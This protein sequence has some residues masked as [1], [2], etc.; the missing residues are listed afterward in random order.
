ML[1]QEVIC[2][3]SPEAQ[4]LK[5]FASAL[6]GAVSMDDGVP[7]IPPAF[8]SISEKLAPFISSR[9][10]GDEIFCLVPSLRLGGDVS[11]DD[12]HS[13]SFAKKA[14][15][16]AV[17]K[18]LSS[19]I[20]VSRELVQTMP[21]T[22]TI[23]FLES[24]MALVDSRVKSYMAA[25]ARQAK[26]DPTNRLKPVVRAL[27]SS[28]LI[29]STAIIQRF[30]VVGPSRRIGHSQLIAPLSIE[31]LVDLNI[32][33]EPYSV[34]VSGSGTICGTQEERTGRLTY[35]KITVDTAS[36]LKTM[37]L[38]AR[39]VVK[40][41]TGAFMQQHLFSIRPIRTD[42]TIEGTFN[43]SGQGYE[44]KVI[45][46]QIEQVISTSPDHDISCV[47][48]GSSISTDEMSCRS[49]RDNA[50]DRLGI[51]TNAAVALSEGHSG[52]ANVH[53]SSEDGEL[54]RANQTPSCAMHPHVF[55][56]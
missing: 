47:E 53:E 26:K 14:L 39:E 2:P 42:I 38:K 7:S 49:Q 19:S 27:H 50:L 21:P 3:P 41:A 15:E 17:A 56:V 51:L 52:V 36:M 40:R 44:K 9:I 23:N 31:S 12:N 37:M 1:D 35:V 29:K 4:L 16:A 45:P 33:G 30:N 43:K 11:R 34:T 54:R 8:Q 28:D 13:P 32:L 18:E 55:Q 25:M 46:T 22:T 24:F 48:A 6:T 20:S 5:E 10:K